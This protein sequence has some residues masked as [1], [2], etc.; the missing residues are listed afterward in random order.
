MAAPDPMARAAS[1]FAAGKV[2]EAR[3]ACDAILR[4]QPRHFYALHLLG[5]I[6]ARR[7]EAEE[8]VDFTTRALEIDPTHVE[9]L[10]NRGAALRLLRRYDDALRDYDKALALAP[11]SAETIN[12]RG[13][14]LA[15]LGRHEEAL[16]SYD[17]ALALNPA[18]A[19]A[20]YN[21]ALSRLMLHRFADGWDDY[22]SRWAGGEHVN[23]A[24]PFASPL[25]GT[26]EWGQGHRI[27]L[28][29]EQGLGDQLLFSTLVPEME[30]RGER[31]TLEADARLVA[32]FRRAHPAWDVVPA[33]SSD[34]A[35]AQCDR[36]LPTGSLPR[37]LRPDIES[38]SRQP[39]ALLAAD[40]GRRAEY[41]QRLTEAGRLLVGLSWRSF[42]PRDRQ[43]FERRKSAPLDA[44]LPLARAPHVRLVDLQY[45]DTSVEREAFMRQGGA[46]QRV[47]ELDLFN[48]IDGLLALIEACDV[49]ITTSNVTAHLA[50]AV[51]KHALV[52][53]P[54]GNPAFHYWAPNREGRSPWYP[55]VE[56]VSAPR[57]KSWAP[58]VEA[59]T[60]RLAAL[61]PAR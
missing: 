53:F 5:V 41:R 28:W 8:C 14:S 22:E 21:R 49:V 44:F 11:D 37:L 10:R 17:R 12:N 19:R 46:L 6:A 47:D 9:V 32:A 26:H 40:A 45:G 31:F 61:S 58:V 48:D 42:Q 29:R 24:R 23:A 20:R 55:S 38:F 35:L 36:H 54:E 18:Y 25:F 7:G 39:R 59:A 3:A 15:A 33:D 52:L 30:A 34:A 43:Y 60:Q 57:W 50:G 4:D 51:G 2:D 13:V 27:A 1:L 16:Q 56:I